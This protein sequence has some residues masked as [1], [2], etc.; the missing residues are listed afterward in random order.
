[1]TEVNPQIL[2][3]ARRSAGLTRE[4]AARKLGI[5]DA[6]GVRAADRLA[7]LEAGANEPT[8]PL[9]VKMAKQYRRPLLTFYLRSPPRKADRGVDFRSLPGDGPAADEALLDALL[10]DVRA[11]Q[12]MVR[13]LLEEEEETQ[14]LPFVGARTIADGL[15]AAVESLRKL[16][17]MDHRDYRAQKTARAA[18][19]LLRDRAEAAGIFVLLKGDLGSH[20]TAIEVETFRGFAMADDIVPFVVIN[21][22][23]SP[24]AW[25]FTLLHELTHLLLGQTG[26]SGFR[27]ESRTERFCNDVASTFLLPA[28][29]KEL[30]AIDRSESLDTAAE[31]VTSF[32]ESRN[33]SSS[34]VAYAAL[35]AGIIEQNIYSELA[36][37]FRSQWHQARAARRARTDEQQGGPSYYIVRQHRVGNAL[38]GLAR[39]MLDAKALTTSKAATIL[40]VSPKNVQTLIE[41][42]RPI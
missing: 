22:R 39:R 32:A 17:G 2:T 21:D 27:A 31:V 26:V 36:E 7:A 28:R 12:S 20:H 41:T 23:D 8:R 34:M 33:L 9:L 5:R 4:E 38:I 6:R 30:L 35:R 40:G 42:A 14:P 24:S 3:W 29:E 10:R 13:C 18:F 16:L 25:S 1:M 37:R 15:A 19:A 11:R